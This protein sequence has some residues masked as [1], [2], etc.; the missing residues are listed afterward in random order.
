MDP[1]LERF[2]DRI[3]ENPDDF[4]KEE[5]KKFP[6]EYFIQDKLKSEYI[7]LHAYFYDKNSNEAF[8]D[9]NQADVILESLN[10]IKALLDDEN[11]EYA[12]Y[13]L[14]SLQLVMGLDIKLNS[15]IYNMI[16][17]NVQISDYVDVERYFGNT[18]AIAN[19][20]K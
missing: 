18:D 5:Y 10:E 7:S 15:V 11:Y 19:K 13:V 6:Q 8:F 9:S 16:Y 14:V 1:L 17:Y 2:I 12:S 20:R 3:E 4:I